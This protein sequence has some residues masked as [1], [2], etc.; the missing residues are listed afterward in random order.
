MVVWNLGRPFSELSADRRRSSGSGSTL[1]WEAMTSA[2]Q[3]VVALLGLRTDAASEPNSVEQEA[4]DEDANSALP[5]EPHL[6]PPFTKASAKGLAKAPEKNSADIEV[7]YFSE[8]MGRYRCE[9][10]EDCSI[11]MLKPECIQVVSTP[12][13]PPDEGFLQ[14]T[15]SFL[16]RNASRDSSVLS[17]GCTL[18]KLR[19]RCE[20]PSGEDLETLL[21]AQ[22]EST[23]VF[24]IEAVADLLKVKSMPSA[25][26]QELERLDALDMVVWNL[27]KPF[28]ELSAEWRR[29]GG[30]GSTLQ[31]EAMTSAEQTV[32]ALLGLRTEAAS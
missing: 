13:V 17:G 1:Q 28:C 5:D 20:P 18:S 29:T 23:S 15:A 32:V 10:L 6:I 22:P 7:L 8:T 19:R 3:T 2:E 16:K 14:S 4:M 30:S 24:R 12:S 9:F 26:L 25:E 11:G 31:W 27:G 21:R